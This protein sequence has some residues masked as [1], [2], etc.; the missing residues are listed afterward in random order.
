MST[1]T[2]EEGEISINFFKGQNEN[3]S[4]PGKASF[5]VKEDHESA[6]R[7]WWDGLLQRAL[8]TRV[9][10]EAECR[11]VGRCSS[12]DGLLGWMTVPVHVFKGLENC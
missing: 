2:L 10:V 12:E 6:R 3:Q 11:L 4:R 1:K 9:Q 5:T 7:L 8:R